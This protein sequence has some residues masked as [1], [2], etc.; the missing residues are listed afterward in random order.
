[1]II[2]QNTGVS[3][4][5]Y[6]LNIVG[7]DSRSGTKVFDYETYDGEAT[8][9]FNTMRIEDNGDL[10]VSGTYEN[11]D[12]I[13]EVNFDGVFILKLS[14]EGKKQLFTK[15]SYKEKIQ[16][17]LKSATRSNGIG[18]KDKFFLEDVIHENGSYSIV[19]ESFRKNY[20]ASNLGGA[21]KLVQN[22]KDVASGKWIGY[23]NGT[24]A[25]T[26]EIMD[27][28]VIRFDEQGNY[29]ETKPLMKEKYNKI[30]VYAPY[31]GFGGL[32]L[33]RLMRQFGWFDYGFASKSP[34]NG[35]NILICSDQSDKK[36]DVYYYE[37]DNQFKK[38]TLNLRQRA[39]VLLDDDARV[40][41]FRVLRNESDKVAVVYYQ[42]K[43]K[44][45]SLTLENL[46]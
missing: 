38:N 31:N 42:R 10:L 45:A 24:A 2:A 13:G 18:S 27:Y 4:A 34:V 6:R 26:F 16:Q 21:F 28:M 46:K 29:L 22:I 5:K 9:V 37:L 11:N 20:Q 41:Y 12:Y 1:L 19:G 32:R 25:M 7:H 35:K 33:A 15:V 30:S 43:V 14:T 39:Q 40:N 44:K 17:V 23:D 36:P 3:I 8:P